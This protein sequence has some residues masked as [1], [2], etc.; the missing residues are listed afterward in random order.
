MLSKDI[1]QGREWDPSFRQNEAEGLM[2]EDALWHG[3]YL[4]KVGRWVMK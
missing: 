4:Q 2:G 1:Y 3:V